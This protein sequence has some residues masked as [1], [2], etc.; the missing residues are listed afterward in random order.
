MN[1]IHH[2]NN[3]HILS[4]R[5]TPYVMLLGGTVREVKT[6]LEQMKVMFDERT[7]LGRL[8]SPT[9]QPCFGAEQRSLTEN[10]GMSPT[11][12]SSSSSS[13]TPEQRHHLWPPEKGKWKRKTTARIWQSDDHDGE[14]TRMP[15][16][17]V[18]RKF[19]KHLK[20]DP[21]HCDNNSKTA[22]KRF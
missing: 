5:E 1:E 14:S 19:R 22:W 12:M 15:K 4:G 3:S 17:I 2:V 7:S 21:K 16:N 8:A 11:P 20:I 9:P 6:S 18:K 10:L 13:L